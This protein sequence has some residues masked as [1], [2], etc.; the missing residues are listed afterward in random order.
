MAM[1]CQPALLIADEPTSGLDATLQQ[2][3][4]DLLRRQVEVL[5]SSMLLITHDMGVVGSTCEDV[6]VMYGGR[7][8]EVGPTKLVLRHPVHPYTEKLIDSFSRS[9]DG[10]MT[11][12]PGAVGPPI[13]ELKG[14]PFSDRCH[15]ADQECQTHLP[16][17][18]HKENRMVACNKI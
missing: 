12:I 7:I 18:M 4:L 17:L 15:K 3:V 13:S 8:M 2:Q 1:A 16:Q 5:K 9:K 10:K 14:C 6:A 11:S